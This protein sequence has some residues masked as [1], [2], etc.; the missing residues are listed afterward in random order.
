MA[1]LNQERSFREA[2]LSTNDQVERWK[3]TL[4]D[5]CG[6][7]VA[8][9]QKRDYNLKIV[10]PHQ[11]MQP[12]FTSAMG[13]GWMEEIWKRLNADY[14]YGKTCVALLED[15]HWKEVDCFVKKR[16]DVDDWQGLN[17]ADRLI[18]VVWHQEKVRCTYWKQTVESLLDGIQRILRDNYYKFL[19]PIDDNPSL[20]E[21][22]DAIAETAHEFERRYINKY[23]AAKGASIRTRGKH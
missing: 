4:P 20:D 16:C 1:M 22:Q 11:A 5:N 6:A 18:A 19:F 13:R 21:M 2:G 17:I 23:G 14:T 9:R 12:I 15:E 7:R 8:A 10:A 3:A